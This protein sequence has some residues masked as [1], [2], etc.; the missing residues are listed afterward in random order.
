[1][2]RTRLTHPGQVRA[3]RDGQTREERG[4]EEEEERA[5]NNSDGPGEVISPN[6]SSLPANTRPQPSQGWRHLELSFISDLAGKPLVN[7]SLYVV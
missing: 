2:T 3:E 5:T 1:M 7:H 4:R 6:Q